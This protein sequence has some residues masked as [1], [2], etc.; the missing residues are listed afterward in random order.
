MLLDDL[1]WSIGPGMRIGIVGVNGSGKTTGLR[2]LQAELAPDSGRIKRGS[3]LRIGYLSQ[4]VTELRGTERVLESVDQ[5]R[6][7]ARLSSGGEG[8]AGSLL[9]AFGFTGDK[10]TTRLDD[11]S[12]GERRR[13]QMLRILLDEPNVLLLDEP[14]NHLDIYT[15][16]VF[17]DC[18]DTWPGTLVLVSHDRYFLE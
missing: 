8:S 2:L 14:T 15:L 13:L 12:G 11:L 1:S 16:T 4:D 6:R 17:E 10:L 5:L 7:Q 18:L 9:A 3:T